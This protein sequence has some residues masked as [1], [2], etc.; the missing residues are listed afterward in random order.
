MGSRCVMVSLGGS[1][2]SVLGIGALAVL[3]ACR[4]GPVDGTTASTSEELSASSRPSPPSPTPN[5]T[6]TLEQFVLYAEHSVSLGDGDEVRSGDVGVRMTAPA[7]FGD[8]LLLGRHVE[9]TRQQLLYSPTVYVGDDAR[10]G[11]LQARMVDNH[12][13]FYAGQASFPATT[14]PLLP[15]APPPMPGDVPVTV[16]KHACA[17]LSPGAYAALSVD[18]TLFLVPGDYTFASVTLGKHARIVALPSPPSPPS[19]VAAAGG[20]ARV[21]VHVAATMVL[22]E[23]A[24]IEARDFDDR[25]CEDDDDVDRRGAS[26]RPLGCGPGAPSLP[27]FEVAGRDRPAIQGVPARPAVFIGRESAVTAVLVAARG[28]ISAGD[29]VSLRGAFGAFDVSIGRRARLELD[30]GIPSTVSPQHGSQQLSNYATN[31]DA[32]VIAPVPADAVLHVSMGLPLRDLTGLRSYIKRT[33][34][35]RDPSYRSHLSVAQFAAAYGPS[36]G[37]YDAVASWAT[38]N[39]LTIGSRYENR[40]LLD[41][42][43]P[44]EALERALFVSFNLAERPDGSTFYT[45]DRQPSVALTPAL[46]RISGTD[47]LVLGHPTSGSGTSGRYRGTDFRNAYATSHL[48]DF[49]CAGGSGSGQTVGLFQLDVYDPNDIQSYATAAGL[50][51]IDVTSVAEVTVGGGYLSAGSSSFSGR[52]EVAGDI[53]L[54]ASMAPGAKQ[55]VFQAPLDGGTSSTNGALNQ[56][57]TY[58]PLINQLSS[59]W[60]FGVDENTQQIV[61][62]MAAQGQSFFQ[63]SGDIG[64]VLEQKNLRYVDGLAVTGGTNLVMGS[65][66]STYTS[67]SAWSCSGGGGLGGGGFFQVDSIGL[68]DFQVDLDVSSNGGSKSFRNLPDVSMVAGPVDIFVDGRFTGGTGTSAAAP[69]WAGFLALANEQNALNHRGAAGFVNPALYAIG[70]TPDL[71]AETFNDITDGDNACGRPS[72][73]ESHAVPGFDLVTGWGTPKCELLYTLSSQNPLEPETRFSVVE[74]VIAT[75][76]D[77]LRDDSEATVSLTLPGPDLSAPLKLSGVGGWGPGTVHQ[78]L[79]TLPT[80][81]TQAELDGRGPLVVTLVQHGSPPETDDNWD[82]TA[83]T[84]RFVRPARPELCMMDLVANSRLTGSVGSATFPS[85]GAGSG[86][87]QTP[88]VPNAPPNQIEFILSTGDDDARNNTEIKANL[89]A[90]PAAGAPFQTF[91]LKAE[92]DGGFG[93]HTA[94]HKVFDGLDSSQSIDHVTIEIVEHNGAFETDDNWDLEAINVA[95]F[96]GDGPITCV[97][98]TRGTPAAR[99]TGSNRSAP[100]SGGCP[101]R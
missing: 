36:Q 21:A 78:V 64:T 57:A 27:V 34:D 38:A 101:N 11:L 35:P 3:G 15:H 69:L 5:P 83:V 44:V 73:L 63:S 89:F 47:T 10:V 61:Y 41:V 93:S 49:A 53:E 30:T 17:Q 23:G 85:L 45:I 24:K 88:G 60:F 67:E 99:L 59:S 54:V 48:A 12:G 52:R 96:N 25:R 56:M 68:P 14:M 91:V 80:P 74:L 18:G 16:R 97:A 90:S 70:K 9:T 100:F 71:Y 65:G 87:I 81:L 51:P 26:R 58:Q 86:C 33:S 32:P 28:T 98:E 2:R 1:V 19:S 46:L 7:A 6:P 92:G 37:D 82:I 29:E 39:G 72:G 79:L 43:G 22:G 40:L 8:Q 55:V 50:P 84:A 75:G 20:P 42:G 66:G 13:G 77:D 76:D 4:G 94:F 31:F 62:A 95:T